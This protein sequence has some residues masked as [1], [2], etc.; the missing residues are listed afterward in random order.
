MF[1]VTQAAVDQLAAGRGGVAGQVVFFAKK[2]RQATSS[3]VGGDAHAVD[4]AADNGEVIDVGKG[5]R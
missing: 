1:Q 4:A 5:G 2:H 3:R